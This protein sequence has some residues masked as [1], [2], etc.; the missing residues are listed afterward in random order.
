MQKTVAELKKQGVRCELLAN[1]QPRMYYADQLQR[2]LGRKNEIA[3]YVLRLHDS[4]YDVAFIKDEKG[5]Y[6]PVF[7]MWRTPV[8]P[9]GSTLP[10]NPTGR[11]GISDVLGVPFEGQEQHWAGLKKETAEML[12]GVG[13]LTRTY[14]KHAAMNK[15]MALGKPIKSVTT[16]PTGKVQIRIKLN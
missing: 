5:S 9:A 11:Y 1:A 14:A 8:K 13:K 16:S 10:D 7:D 15:A 6:Q 12:Y 3:D 2:H 4:P